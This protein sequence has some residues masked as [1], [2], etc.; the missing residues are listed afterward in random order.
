[1]KKV[2]KDFF[3]DELLMLYN[4]CNKRPIIITAI[5]SHTD[6]ISWASFVKIKP[7]LNN[8]QLKNKISKNYS[9]CKHINIDRIGIEKYIKLS[10][11]HDRKTFIIIAN[12]IKYNYYGMERIG[13]KLYE[14]Y[15][16]IPIKQKIKRIYISKPIYSKCY[17]YSIDDF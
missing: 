11:S 14:E 8:L 7:Y 10:S 3:R 15:N 2:E 1:M 12:I 17:E 4:K 5:Y 16:L 9:F 6:N 13:L